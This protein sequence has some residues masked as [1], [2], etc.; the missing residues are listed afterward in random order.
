VI[1]LV[2]AARRSFK[3]CEY[4]RYP[5]AVLTAFGTRDRRSVRRSKVA[6]APIQSVTGIVAATRAKNRPQRISAPNVLHSRSGGRLL[7]T[8]WRFRWRLL[9]VVVL[10]ICGDASKPLE[11]GK[12]AAG[13]EFPERLCADA[14]EVF[15][16]T[17]TALDVPRAMP[18]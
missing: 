3:D 13:S 12:G 4:S 10:I 6:S 5:A 18:V 17:G 15:V 7:D 14:F 9:V 16:A 1:G 8:P 2:T 11:V